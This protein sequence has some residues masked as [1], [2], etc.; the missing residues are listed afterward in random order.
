MSPVS[1]AELRTM[2]GTVSVEVAAAALGVGRSTCYQA[3][4][5]DEVPF[6]TVVVGRR[7]K[8]LTA[9]LIELLDGREAAA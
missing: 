1:V 8:V 4:A 9:T 5:N 3:I 6:R 2:P 7:I